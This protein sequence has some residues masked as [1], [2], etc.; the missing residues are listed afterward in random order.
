VMKSELHPAGARYT[1]LTEVRLRLPG[2]SAP[3]TTGTGTRPEP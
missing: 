2:G 3:T 1:A